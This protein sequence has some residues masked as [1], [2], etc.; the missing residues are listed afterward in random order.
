[1]GAKVHRHQATSGDIQRPLPRLSAMPGDVRLR[2][3]TGRS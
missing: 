1:V 3:A 2:Q